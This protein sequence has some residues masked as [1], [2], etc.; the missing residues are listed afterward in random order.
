MEKSYRP[1]ST[2]SDCDAS[3][4]EIYTSPS[5][6]RTAGYFS[7]QNILIFLLIMTNIITIAKLSVHSR[8]RLHNIAP[9]APASEKLAVVDAFPEMY[10]AFH[11]WTAYGSHNHT[12]DDTLWDAINPS[13]GFI[14]ID[15]KETATK[16]W[17]STMYLPS[18]ESKGVY[19]LEAYHQLHCLVSWFLFPVECSPIYHLGEHEMKKRH[20]ITE[21]KDSG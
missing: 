11:W 20:V 17:R 3:E 8:S 16:H 5:G 14:A 15:R 21:T 6:T 12:R 1:L 2:S 19:L 13:H 18:D 4:D 10:T 7:V 9:S